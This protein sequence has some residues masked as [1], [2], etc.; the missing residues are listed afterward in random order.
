M[1]SEP[2]NQT[3]L[4]LPEL[5]V[6]AGSISKLRVAL[7]YGAD[8]VYVGACGFSMRPDEASM[9][10]DQLRGAVDYT[11]EL[12]KRIYV[13]VNIM[14]FDDDI[15]R[16]R[17]WLKDSADIAIDAMIVG[18]AGA[19]ASVC[20]LRP[21]MPVHISTQMSTAN[22]A[23]ATAWCDAG[24]SR[25]VLAREC[26]F[27]Q[28]RQ[29]A[30]GTEIEVETFVHGAMCMAISGRCLISATLCGK[31]ASRGVCKHSCRWEWNLVEESRPGQS[32]PVQET[33]HGTVL[34]GSSD[35]CLLQHL[36]ELV[37]SGVAALKI[38]GRMKG[39]HYIATVT[40]VYRAA[41]DKY[42]SDPDGFSVDPEWL[43]EL[44]AVSHR[45]YSTGFAFGYSADRPESLQAENVVLSSCALVG[46]VKERSGNSHTVIAK[47]PFEVGEELE[48]IGPNGGGTVI[49]ASICSEDGDQVSRS[50]SGTM[51]TVEFA[52]GATLP[53][54]AMMRRRQSQSV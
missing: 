5:L 3:S 15:A 43:A 46:F 2:D 38:E 16:F 20:E 9:T 52:E 30:S 17:Q 28:I 13:A 23:A 40:R 1:D 19:L 22:A 34:L 8:A 21:S 14:M 51:I 42:A 36:P 18:D 27:E 39:E 26:G 12:R 24:A 37:S 29:I 4:A 50:Q 11:H 10:V 53:Q 7:A 6:P 31:S 32:F 44:E 45:P 47:N 54:H 48:W 41:L 35:L 49:A 25:I 33:D